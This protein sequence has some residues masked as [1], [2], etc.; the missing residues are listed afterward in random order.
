MAINERQCTRC[1]STN[2]LRLE[3]GLPTYDAYLAAQAGKFKLGGC[4]IKGDSPNYYCKDCENEWNWRQ[5]VESAHQKIKFIKVCTFENTAPAYSVEM[6]VVQHTISWHGKARIA[7]RA[8]EEPLAIP[9]ELYSRQEF[10]RMLEII[11]LL[12]WKAKYINPSEPAGLDWSLEIVRTGRT[13]KKQ[14]RNSYPEN[15]KYFC[16]LIRDMTGQEFE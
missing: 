16:K 12:N 9:I 6:D 4:C 8:G 7:A 15:W 14:G 1:G 13:I 10:L 5:A 11:D 3:Y 2:V